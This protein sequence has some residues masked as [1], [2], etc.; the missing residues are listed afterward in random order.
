MAEITISNILIIGTGIIGRCCCDWT[1]IDSQIRYLMASVYKVLKR[2]GL[3]GVLSANCKEV[4]DWS[5]IL[6][7]VSIELACLQ[8]FD[9]EVVLKGL[10]VSFS[11]WACMRGGIERCLV[12]RLDLSDH[13]L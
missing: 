10:E 5:G 7:V 13:I 11:R 8:L 1:F 9:L 12:F 2:A 6:V 3:I 4:P